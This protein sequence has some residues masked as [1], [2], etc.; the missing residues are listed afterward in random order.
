M[1]LAQLKSARVSQHRD[2]IMTYD[3]ARMSDYESDMC[4][5]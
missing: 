1:L 5:L 3:V 2:S 4:N